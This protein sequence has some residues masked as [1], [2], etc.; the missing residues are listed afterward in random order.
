[1]DWVLPRASG[2]ERLP[3]SAIVPEGLHHFERELEGERQR[4]HLRID[5]EG[6]GL[7]IA[8]ASRIVH[9]TELEC[10]IV[11]RL[12]EG[13]TRG[14]AVRGLTVS[15]SRVEELDALLAG[16]PRPGAEYPVFNLPDPAFGDRTSL[17][18]PLQADLDVGDARTLGTILGRCWEAGIPHVRFHPRDGS[19]MAT[20][21]EAVQHAED[22][23]MIT[24]VRL[25]GG[26]SEVEGSLLPLAECGLDYA[27]VPWAG[28]Q[29]WQERIFGSTPGFLERRIDEIKGLEICPVASAPIFRDNEDAL[30]ENGLRRALELGTEQVEVYALVAM[31]ESPASSVPRALP[32]EAL[33]QTAADIEELTS[34][35]PLRVVW[36]PP[37]VVPGGEKVAEAAQR[38]PRTSG[39]ISIRIEEDGRVLAPRGEATAAGNLLTDPWETIWGHAAFCRFRERVEGPTRCALCPG[40][41]ICAADCPA[42]PRGWA[43]P[44]P[45]RNRNDAPG[46][47]RGKG[48]S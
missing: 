37:V 5:P 44:G 48:L 10:T 31:E 21:P 14:E 6:A 38:G 3:A 42:D 16:R 26:G 4:F 18:A 29:E 11:K 28:S 32:G 24:G 8:G 12:L 45:P 9:L 46:K 19:A 25:P 36:L 34:R 30:L 40:L 1:M 41:A 35:I 27:V 17:P 47:A 23:G 7:L 13:R 39:D 22:L 15:R 2:R 43:L 20:L 33:R